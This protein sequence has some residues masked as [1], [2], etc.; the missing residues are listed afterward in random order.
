M[1]ENV[2][3]SFCA[4]VSASS[5]ELVAVLGFFEENGGFSLVL[6]LEKGRQGTQTKIQRENQHPTEG[7]ETLVR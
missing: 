2:S 1:R 5:F 7:R 4:W 3:S 6:F